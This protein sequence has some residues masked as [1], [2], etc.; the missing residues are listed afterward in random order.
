MLL[1][2]EHGR[3]PL[4]LSEVASLSGL[5]PSKAHRYLVS[6]QRVGLASQDVKSGLYDLGPAARHLGLEALRRSDPV[7]VASS[8]A[9]ELRDKTGHT[10]NVSVW[11]EDGPLLVRWDTGTHPLP[12]SMRVGSTLPLLDSAVG[13]VFFAFLPRAVTKS[14]LMAQQRRKETRKIGAA[15]LDELAGSVKASGIARFDTLILGLAAS[16]VPVFG[17]DGEPVLVLGLATPATIS[18][19]AKLERTL[20]DVAGDISRELGYRPA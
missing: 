8:R 15:E 17:P 11:S 3:G 20:L 14:V 19:G 7:S 12:I 6:F 10:V 5:H 9:V 4:T 16:A 2:L 18:G 1:A 13:Q